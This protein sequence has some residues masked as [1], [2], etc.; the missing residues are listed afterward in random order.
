[1]WVVMW[2]G[3]MLMCDLVNDVVAI[4][5]FNEG[6]HVWSCEC[7]AM[8]GGGGSKPRGSKHCELTFLLV[9]IYVFISRRPYYNPIHRWLFSNGQDGRSA[10]NLARQHPTVLEALESA[11]RNTQYVLKWWCGQVLI[12][13]NAWQ[14]SSIVQNSLLSVHAFIYSYVCMFL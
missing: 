12:K 6:C 5:S 3:S 14:E 8:L 11:T 9:E 13:P 7:G 1:M 4:H 10:M 2:C